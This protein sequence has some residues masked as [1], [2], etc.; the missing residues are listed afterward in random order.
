[1]TKFAAIC[2]IVTGLFSCK[3]EILTREPLSNYEANT[4]AEVFK[5][6]WNGM[7]SNY[8]FWD[9]ESIDWDSV[10]RLYKP[11]FDSLD[12]QEYSDTIQN[13]CFQFLADMTKDLKDGQYSLLFWPGGDVY[14]ENK[15]YK[16][17]ISFTPK[18]FRTQLVHDALPDTLFDYIIQYNYLKNFDYGI[19]RDPVTMQPFQIV[20]GTLSKGNKNVIYTSLNSFAIKESYDYNY[21]S[22]PTRPVIKNLFDNIH[23]SNC[24]ALLIDLRNNRGG[25]MEDINFFAGQFTSRP[26]LFG[27]SR[28]KSGTGRLDY[29]PRL[30]MSITP[31]EKAAD[32]KKPIIILTDIYS[33]ALCETVINAFKALPETSVTIIGEHT[34]GTGGFILGDDIANGGSFQVGNF[35]SARV[36]NTAVQDKNGNFNFS[37]IN[38]DIEVKYN[39]SSIKQMLA[40]G[41]DIQL[42]KAI[43]FINQ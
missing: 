15:L 19:Y 9:K 3:R 43:Q 30:P 2:M 22:R 11:K 33:S 20:T 41:V 35:A 7:N 24:D 25:N 28:Y 5:V 31:Q 37:G 40:S 27:Y 10:Y 4:Y 6:F 14:F 42:E 26:V 18:L 32:F 13:R 12:R 36:S 34:Y 16:S 23:R 8:L 39:A 38:P 17:Y 29:T 1:M 21:S